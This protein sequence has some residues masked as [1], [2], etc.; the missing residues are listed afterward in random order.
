[1]SKFYHSARLRAR[2][3]AAPLPVDSRGQ[4]RD[5][6]WFARNPE[7][8]YR[9]RR[10]GVFEEWS[11]PE[12]PP[13]CRWVFVFR[14]SVNFAL[15]LSGNSEPTLVKQ[16]L[17]INGTPADEDD[18][19]HRIFTAEHPPEVLEPGQRFCHPRDIRPFSERQV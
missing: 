19:L 7:R 1:M 12:V 5:F 2:S 13:A 16:H 4:P 15:L 9:V 8:H 14:A 3:A 6:V 11:R 18:A 17:A 10:P